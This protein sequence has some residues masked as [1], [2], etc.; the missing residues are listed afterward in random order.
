VSCSHE[1]NKKPR[2][3]VVRNGR[4]CA[5]KTLAVLSSSGVLA[6]R[7]GIT[8]LGASLPYS[9]YLD[10]IIE[11]QARVEQGRS[12]SYIGDLDL[13]YRYYGIAYRC[14][15][16]FIPIL[17]IGALVMWAASWRYWNTIGTL[18]PINTTSSAAVLD[19]VSLMRG[20]SAPAQS[21][22]E[23]V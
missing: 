16:I 9:L 11:A 13:L 8:L 6:C 14:C 10:R 23:I 17:A 22:M 19:L 5:R 2:T 21:R 1:C 3:R 15:V 18:Q 4:I 12:P 7:A 20:S